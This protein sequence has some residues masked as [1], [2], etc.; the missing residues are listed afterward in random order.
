MNF[1]TDAGRMQHPQARIIP[2]S[3]WNDFDFFFHTLPDQLI[4]LMSAESESALI[5]NLDHLDLE[6]NTREKQ[7]AWLA[8]ALSHPSLSF[9]SLNT[10][11]N[12][13]Q[14]PHKA[15][16]QTAAAWG[17]LNYLRQ[18][19]TATTPQHLARELLDKNCY[20]AFRYAAHHGHTDVLTYI[21]ANVPTH[22]AKMIE[23]NNFY[24]FRLA[25]HHGYLPVL[26]YLASQAPSQ[27]H[28]MI[29][30][31]DYCAFKG[32][33]K[34]GHLAVLHYLVNQIPEEDLP[35]MIAAEDFLSFRSAAEQGHL[36]VLRY[37]EEL[38]PEQ[39]QNMI[40]ADGFSAFRR[41]AENNHFAV[42]DYLAAR[43]RPNQ[44][45]NMIDSNTFYA[46]RMA[47]S[48]KSTLAIN[49]L[50]AQT[51]TF[52]YAEQHLREFGNLVTPFLRQKI[53]ALRMQKNAF[54]V[55]HPNAV[56]NIVNAEESRL[57]F[58]FLRHM[59][60]LEDPDLRDDM[61]FLLEIPSV[62]NIVHT[63]VTP[64]QA[65]ELLRLAL[66]ND[67]QMAIEL[68]LNIP[69]VR[70]LA[71][72]HNYYEAEQLGVLDLRALAQDRESSMTALSKGEQ[73]RLQNVLNAYQ[74]FLQMTG[75]NHC[76]QALK[77]ELIELYK[78][79]PAL[80]KIPGCSDTKKRSLLLPLAWEDFQELDLQEPHYTLALQAYYQN[81][82]HSAWRYLL[83]PNPWMHPHA[84]YVYV[85]PNRLYEKWSSFEEYQPLISILYLAALDHQAEAI[86][87]YTFATRLEHFIEELALIGRAHNWDKTRALTSASGEELTADNGEI[88]N[89]EYDD[90]EGDQP[91]CYSGVKRRLFQSIQG[92]PLFSFLTKEKLTQELNEFV[93]AH[94]QQYVTEANRPV[95][96][97]AWDK[98]LE[99]NEL[100]PADWQSLQCLDVSPARQQ[101]FIHAM[102]EKY[103]LQLNQEPQFKEMIQKA[104][105]YKNRFDAHILN[106]GH[107]HP[108]QF[109]ENPIPSGQSALNSVSF[110]RARTNSSDT[111][112]VV[113]N[114]TL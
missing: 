21:G 17:N 103:G 49:Y 48:N 11:A 111:E 106:F 16:F 19:I 1:E 58:Y 94:I 101:N 78:K 47:A 85:N 91:S 70:H 20:L 77:D 55:A 51:N 37:L 107:I 18:L 12:K 22:L 38:A 71:E 96:K 76:M 14:L 109:F 87:G 74:P 104:F 40:A 24:S 29:K 72:R 105:A 82:Y 46:F 33:A 62:K 50:L 86:D 27:I 52:A 6:N 83:K 75:V 36:E 108:E 63:A 3:L 57:L 89:E 100:S 79:N 9:N 41:A 2:A 45:Q 35:A 59:I 4:P 54:E 23:T 88:I 68:L 97:A 110:F 90:L 81:K 69:A 10:I 32:A 15:L 92:H 31:N 5:T 84:S 98:C 13:L 7:R 95:I 80:I 43:V 26:E 42:M 67:N 30:A 25:A 53:A 112:M 73:K 39:L 64:R 8:I 28:T 113:Q 34:E 61:L 65:N 56:F 60:R 93:R 114:K 66:N 44:L 102:N 99:G